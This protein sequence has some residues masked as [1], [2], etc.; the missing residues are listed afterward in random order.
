MNNVTELLTKL[1]KIKRNNSSKSSV[2]RPARNRLSLENLEGR[3]LLA[4][5]NFSNFSSV[6]SADLNL[7][8]SA[9]ITAENSLRLTPA[10][11]STGAAWYDVDKQIVA[12][13]FET[14][15]QFRLSTASGGSDGSDGFAFVIQN[16]GPTELRAG[17]GGLGYDGMPNSVAVE[18]DTWL[19][20]GAGD[21]YNDPSQSHISVHTNGTGANGTNESYRVG[22]F[23]NTSGFIL[24][25]AQVYTARVRYTPG[26][27]TVFLD[28]LT[29]PVLTVPL[30]L[31]TK[32]GLD[33]G[34]AWVGF[35]G[36]AGGS[37]L[38]QDIFS[39]SF[40]AAENV[41]LA[42]PANVIEGPPNG[43]SSLSF[44]IDRLGATTGSVVVNWSTADGTAS[45]GTDY[46]AASGQAVF[47]DGETQKTVS[48][49]VNGDSALEPDETIRLLLSTTSL[50]VV[51]AGSQG[52]ILADDTAISVGDVYLTEGDATIGTLGPLVSTGLGGLSDPYDMVVSPDGMS[53]YVSARNGSGV[54]RYD[55]T[56]GSPLPAREARSGVHNAEK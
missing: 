13:S 5:F 29:T 51:A 9:A 18:F 30:D 43:T 6:N 45:A 15:F 36:A 33:H 48:V 2:K 41:V 31:N 1:R 12:G 21:P 28:N 10:V 16:S 40:S 8:G 42:N 52:T 38:N 23:Y 49:I 55:A 47:Q 39:W 44:A 17:G 19:N 4:G 32:L 34:R 27:L 22:A 3:S 46:V 37:P 25:N 20:N 56:T 35:T 54:Y 7:L 24:D 53:I 26:T 11:S 14:T 50:G